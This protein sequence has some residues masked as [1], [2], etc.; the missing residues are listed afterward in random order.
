VIR[1]SGDGFKVFSEKGKALSRVLPTKAQAMKRLKQVE[2][3]KHN[4]QRKGAS[5]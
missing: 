1:K 4:K 2:F 3:F 5:K